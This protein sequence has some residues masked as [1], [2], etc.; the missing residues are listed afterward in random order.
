MVTGQRFN[1]KIFRGKKV[2]QIQDKLKKDHL[3]TT[4]S[5]KEISTK[6]IVRTLKSLKIHLIKNRLEKN[7]INSKHA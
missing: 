5:S 4:K 7:Q 3:Q 2:N 1:F 6:V